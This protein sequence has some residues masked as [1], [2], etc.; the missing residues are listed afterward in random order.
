MP[1][2]MFRFQLKPNL[3]FHFASRQEALA[4]ALRSLPWLL[5][6]HQLQKRN[7]FEQTRV[8]QQVSRGLAKAIDLKVEISGLEFLPKEPCIIVPLHEGMFDVLALLHLPLAMRF[9]ARSELFTWQWLGNIIKATQSIE[10]N[11]ESGISSYRRL[12]HQAKAVLMR[13]EHLVIFPQGSVCGLEIAFQRGAFALA[14]TLDVPILPIVLTGSHR[15]WDHPFHPD[16]QTGQTIN[17][18][19]L[20]AQRNPE[21]LSLQRQMKQLALQQT[22]TPRHYLPKR[23]GYWD[24]YVFEIDRQFPQI[25]AEISLYRLQKGLNPNGSKTDNQRLLESTA[26]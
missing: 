12:L 8:L 19:I 24:G 10:V 22:N 2:F 7:L 21:M 23:D 25:F 4:C 15:V 18:C 6:L 13:S 3:V 16:L 11:P 26:F 14:K 1:F 17:L 9:A 20:E 5:Q